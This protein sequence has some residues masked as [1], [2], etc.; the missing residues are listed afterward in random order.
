MCLGYVK[1]AVKIN[2]HSGLA[3]SNLTSLHCPHLLKSSFF[4]PNVPQIGSQASAHG[5]WDIIQ[6]LI[7]MVAI[8]YHIWTLAVL[9]LWYQEETQRCSYPYISKPDKPTCFPRLLSLE[10]SLVFPI[11]GALMSKCAYNE[12]LFPPRSIPGHQPHRSNPSSQK[13]LMP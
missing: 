11:R 5:F 7:Y 1:L 13:S 6:D 9:P 2:E 10:V 4:P 12:V 3:S 8:T